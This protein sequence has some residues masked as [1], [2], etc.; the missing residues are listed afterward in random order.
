MRKVYQKKRTYQTIFLKKKTLHCLGF[1]GSIFSMKGKKHMT[2]KQMQQAKAIAQSD[3]CLPN[4]SL[5]CFAG[6]CLASFE[7]VTCSLEQ[8]AKFI[9]HQCLCFD[10]KTWDEDAYKDI[11]YSRKKFII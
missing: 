2:I 11:L 3:A 7:P 9:R 10:G 6:L 8:V 1:L 5:D 4:Y